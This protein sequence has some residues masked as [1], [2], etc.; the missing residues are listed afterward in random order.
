[1][2]VSS[3]TVLPD[4]SDSTRGANTP[5]HVLR[6]KCDAARI[7]GLVRSEYDFLVV[8]DGQ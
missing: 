4:L 7:L 2:T 1:M 3:P 8:Y 6:E 5:L